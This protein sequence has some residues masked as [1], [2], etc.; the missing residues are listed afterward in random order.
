MRART[1]VSPQ[2]PRVCRR[3]NP[4]AGVARRSQTRGSA[5]RPPSRPAVPP[6]PRRARLRRSSRLCNVSSRS[7]GGDESGSGPGPAVAASA[8]RPGKRTARLRGRLAAS[9]APRAALRT[10]VLL[11]DSGPGGLRPRT[12]D[13][14][15]RGPGTAPWDRPGTS[16]APRLH[17]SPPRA[18]GSP[19][20]SRPV[21]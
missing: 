10:L 12:K 5:P 19:R 21:I 17:A 3:R 20:R 6:P 11:S 14:G 7:G 1:A 9:G 8:A 13:H 18:A 2:R 16:A 4:A 15:H